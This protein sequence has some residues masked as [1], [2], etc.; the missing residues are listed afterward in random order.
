MW[1]WRHLSMSLCLSL[2]AH[3]EAWGLDAFSPWAL[4]SHQP[5][6]WLMKQTCPGCNRSLKWNARHQP[7]LDFGDNLEIS[8]QMLLCENAISHLHWTCLRLH[9]VWQ[10]IPS[11][12]GAV[13][14]AMRSGWESFL[15]FKNFFF[16]FFQFIFFF[17]FFLWPQF[18]KGLPMRYSQFF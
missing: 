14:R 9:H 15:I 3:C 11:K 2:I 16:F 13:E 5:V 7:L 1:K 18:S 4:W 17:Y 6:Q 8:M 12:G 10:Q